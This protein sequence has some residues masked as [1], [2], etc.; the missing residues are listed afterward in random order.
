MLS[1]SFEIWRSKTDMINKSNFENTFCFTESKFNFYLILISKSYFHFMQISKLPH[2]KTL[3]MCILLKIIQNKFKMQRQSKYISCH[4]VSSNSN[5]VDLIPISP[6]K[7]SIIKKFSLIIG[8]VM[9]VKQ[10]SQL[11]SHPSSARVSRNRAKIWKGALKD[12]IDLILLQKPNTNNISQIQ[13]MYFM[14]IVINCTDLG[15]SQGFSLYLVWFLL[16]FS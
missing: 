5:Q 1:F 3:F 2:N 14:K 16:S 9:L 15:S 6:I 4:S 11:S 8:I 7:S 10:L 13:I 12:I